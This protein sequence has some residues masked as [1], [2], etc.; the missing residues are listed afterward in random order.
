MMHIKL[1]A[2]FVSNLWGPDNKIGGFAGVPL[3]HQKPGAFDHHTHNKTILA[4]ETG[5]LWFP[6]AAQ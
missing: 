6:V 2:E 1:T 3:G 5:S 4:R